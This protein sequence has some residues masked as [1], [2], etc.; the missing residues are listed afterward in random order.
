MVMV[1]VDP[2]AVSAA[3][4]SHN[5]NILGDL[6]G[7]AVDF[8]EYMDDDCETGTM[9]T[10]DGSQGA[11]STARKRSAEEEMASDKDSVRF[12]KKRRFQSPAK[13]PATTGTH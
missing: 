4:S 7:E 2:M 12:L 9:K 3:D 8:Y 11:A 10:Q 5:C 1:D 13:S 6:L